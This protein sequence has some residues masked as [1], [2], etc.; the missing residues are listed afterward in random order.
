M[1]YL[2]PKHQLLCKHQNHLSS[3]SVSN[4]CWLSTIQFW[5]QQDRYKIDMILRQHLDDPSWTKV[6]QLDSHH[7]TKDKF[8]TL[9][10]MNPY[11]LHFNLQ[12]NL[13]ILRHEAIFSITFN[14]C[15]ND[16]VYRISGDFFQEREAWVKSFSVAPQILY[17]ATWW[18][19][20][21]GDFSPKLI[22][23]FHL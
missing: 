5:L 17:M 15:I 4:S 12:F 7:Q 21:F 20:S 10:A 18:G 22:Q 1:A 2:N 6:F 11:N 13:A 19:T 9:W 16:Y 3:P 14:R 23:I 8:R